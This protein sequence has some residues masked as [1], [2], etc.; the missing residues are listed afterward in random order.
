MAPPLLLSGCR[1]WT[2]QTE[3]NNSR[4]NIEGGPDHP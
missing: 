4:V 1:F 2:S 3:Y